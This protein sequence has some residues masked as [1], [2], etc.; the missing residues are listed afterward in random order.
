M[1]KTNEA[2]VEAIV[3]TAAPAI[4]QDVLDQVLASHS[5]TSARI[6]ALDA[7]GYKRGAIASA[8]GKRYQHVRNVL[9]QPLKKA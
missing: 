3:T 2:A 7:M 6:R 5:T 4:A 1:T 9:T 8:L